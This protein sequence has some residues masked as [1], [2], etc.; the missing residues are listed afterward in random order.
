MSV[1]NFKVIISNIRCENVQVPSPA[2]G[3]HGFIKVSFRVDYAK[4]LIS[5]IKLCE[6]ILILS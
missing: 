3:L 5:L 1:S 6:M 2:K 4:L